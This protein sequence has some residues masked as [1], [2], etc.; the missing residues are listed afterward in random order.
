MGK[1]IFVVLNRLD[2][3]Q[4]VESWGSNGDVRSRRLLYFS[5]LPSTRASSA[6]PPDPT[7]PI[8][9]PIS[10]IRRENPR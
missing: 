10:L 5:V 3:M 9:C 2:K 1:V 7:H 4:E 6:F 8:S